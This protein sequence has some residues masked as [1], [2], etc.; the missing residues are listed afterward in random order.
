MYLKNATMRTSVLRLIPFILFGGLFLF[1]LLNAAGVL[2][3]RVDFTWL[4]RVVSTLFVFFVVFGFDRVFHR[5]AKRPM[6]W[7]VW[8]SATL[9]IL[10]DF[11]GDFFQ[12]YSRWVWY[13]QG[14]HFLSGP[15]IVL[16]LY[17]VIDDLAHSLGWHYPHWL[18][19][20]MSLCLNVL[21]A[22]LYEIEEYTED[23]FYGTNRLGDGPDT[24]ND[25]LLNLVGGVLVILGIVAYRALRNTI[26]LRMFAPSSLRVASMPALERKRPFYKKRSHSSGL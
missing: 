3:F 20:G 21:F 2:R 22:V 25:L 26:R 19:Y 5:I 24:A 10:V 14:A 4:G 7:V 1:E 18:S 12:L 17:F 23:F 13:D 16:A 9:L 11:I 15:L 6:H 8:L